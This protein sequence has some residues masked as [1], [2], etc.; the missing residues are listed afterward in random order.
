MPAPPSTALDE[1]GRTEDFGPTHQKAADESEQHGKKTKRKRDDPNKIYSWRH[2]YRRPKLKD[3][4]PGASLQH[5]MDSAPPPPPRRVRNATPGSLMRNL[6][7][8][9]H[10]R[11][12]LKEIRADFNAEKDTDGKRWSKKKGDLINHNFKSGITMLQ[13]ARWLE[14]HGFAEVR[15]RGRRLCLYKV[16]NGKFH[17][18]LILAKGKNVVDAPKAGTVKD[19]ATAV[20]VNSESGV[21]GWISDR[22]ARKRWGRIEVY[23]EIKE[24]RAWEEAERRGHKI[25]DKTKSPKHRWTYGIVPDQGVNPYKDYEIGDWLYAL[26]GGNPVKRRVRQI[27]LTWGDEGD[28]LIG[29]TVSDKIPHRDVN[30]EHKLRELTGKT[31]G[32]TSIR[33]I[34]TSRALS[35]DEAPSAPSAPHVQSRAG[36]VELTWDGLDEEG[37]PPVFDQANVELHVS[38]EEGFEPSDQTFQ[39][40]ITGAGPTSLNLLD[41]ETP[42]Y[43][44]LVA[45]DTGGDRSA[46]SEE[47]S[48][49]MQKINTSDIAPGAIGEEELSVDFPTGP[50]G[51]PPVAAPTFRAVPAQGQIYII[52]DG[53]VNPDPVKYRIYCYETAGITP[54]AAEL[55]LDDA[56]AG[57]TP[58]RH[59][60]NGT[61]FEYYVKTAEGIETGETKFYYFRVQA[62]EEVDGA[63]PLSAE[64]PGHM[65]KTSGGDVAVRTLVGEHLA[66]KTSI[67]SQL[68][69]PSLT[70]QRIEINNGVMGLNSDDQT[71]F[72]LTID[73]SPHSFSGEAFL[74]AV[75]IYDKLSLAGTDN[76]LLSGAT[77]W[78]R[79]K[80]QD[81]KAK[82]YASMTTYPVKLL[83]SDPAPDDKRGLYWDSGTSHWFYCSTN[84][85]SSTIVEID[86]NG[87]FVTSYPIKNTG[88]GQID[89][90]GGLTRIGTTWYVLAKNVA[91]QAWKVYS[92]AS[93]TALTNNSATALW[94]YTHESS[95]TTRPAL[96]VNAAAG[97][98]IIARAN[99]SE[100]FVIREYSTTGTLM[101]TATSSD[102][103]GEINLTGVIRVPSGGWLFGA[104]DRYILMPLQFGH[105]YIYGTAGARQSN[106]EWDTANDATTAGFGFNGTNFFHIAADNS[107]LTTYT[108]NWWSSGSSSWSIGYTWGDSDTGGTGVHESG[109]SP[110]RVITATKC[111]RLNVTSAA[112]PGG[113]GTDDPNRV[114]WYIGKGSVSNS[115]MYRQTDQA[116]DMISG[117]YDEVVFS[118]DN[119]SSRDPAYPDATASNVKDDLGQ[120]LLSSD[121]S[122]GTFQTGDYKWVA[123][124]VTGGGVVVN[125][126]WVSCEGSAVS[127]TSATFGPLFGVIGTTYGN[128]DG[129]TTYNVPNINNRTLFGV[130]MNVTRGQTEG[131][132][133]SNRTPLHQHTIS[134]LGG[135]THSIPNTSHAKVS[136][137]TLTGVGDRVI[138]IAGQNAGDHNHGGDTTNDG[139]HDH[140]GNTGATLG[141]SVFPHLGAHLLIKL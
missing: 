35:D 37:L 43:T 132:V 59:L 135:H 130:G 69:V 6:L 131:M 23:E 96:G 53:L 127:R 90:Q 22:K 126:A 54:S 95:S 62:Y 88:G 137:T 21:H 1:K 76:A 102:T 78:L 31:A 87:T 104:V 93:L 97:Q 40:T 124:A 33:E 7:Q 139:T 17:N 79:G 24:V 10:A 27:S 110:Y 57:V 99:I 94:N 19:L 128:G 14:T 66:S 46:A 140:G 13:V 107:Y 8:E 50:D 68:G 100:A 123:Y 25:L 114:Y 109:P 3:F 65:D 70:G 117:N 47:I 92:Y 12:A 56:P 51:T 111:A 34:D 116:V 71:T 55:L 121:G 101:N 38:T 5:R 133:E 112:I 108:R 9:A 58:V 28:V 125:N 74:E 39:A 29:L 41:Y 67:T 136:N 72:K 98:L 85:Q 119:L 129:S 120:T 52:I 106:E 63:G 61:P 86:A 16:P 115:T 80:V 103:P 18:S 32:T 45:V 64:I 82:P 2:Y 73:S 91:D 60:P 134:S 118:G 36:T 89:A 26:E 42:Y 122:R 48:V 4:E 84:E 30:N 113:S 77:L 75:E 81:P 138:S 20:F 44:K 141:F 11:G 105:V 49:V 15:M 83:S